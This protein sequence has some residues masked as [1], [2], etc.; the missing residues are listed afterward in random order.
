MVTEPFP[1]A[2]P[3]PGPPG[4]PPPLPASGPAKGSRRGRGAL[5]VGAVIMLAAVIV[6]A[7][8][9][10]IVGM[11]VGRPLYET[12]TNDARSTPV[13]EKLT[14]REG[15]YAVFQLT[16]S[17]TTRGPVTT[18]T[19]NGA[20][21][22]TAKEVK[23]TG[24]DGKAIT[25]SVP[26]FSE[27]LTRA[28]EVYENTVQFTVPEDGVY[29]VRVA[30][31]KAG[32]AKGDTPASVQV[33]I[34]PALGSGFKAVVPWLIAGLAS[35]VAFPVGVIVLIVGAVRRRKRPGRT[36]ARGVPVPDKGWYPA[37]DTPGRQR[38]WDGQ[39]WTQ[40]LR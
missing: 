36:P 31:P 8:S 7:T 18:A 6:G 40:Y 19:G 27:Q 21:T 3:P 29:R 9:A 30:S 20:A 32:T 5:I 33:V 39:A 1:P 13:D 10:T 34:A 35:V 37:P 11:S 24:P 26:T 15:R 4:E 2:G 38:Y 25:T 23:V 17:Q 16:G 22:L 12:L 28:T 14:L